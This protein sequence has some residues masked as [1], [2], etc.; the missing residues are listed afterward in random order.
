M[1]DMAGKSILVTGMAGFIGSNVIVNLVKKYPDYYFVGVDKLSYCSTLKNF[2]EI[3]ATDNFVFIEADITDLSHMEQ[4]FEAYNVKIVLHFAAYTHVDHSFAN[5]IIFTNNN[6]LGTH[7]LLEVSKE[8]NVERFIHV[9]TDEVYGDQQDVISVEETTVLV[10]TNPYAATKAAAEHLVRAYHISFGLPII[11]TRGNNVYG[12]KQYPEKVIPKFIFHL[13]NGEKCPI[14]GTGEQKR[15]FLY[16]EDVVSAFDIILHNGV[17]GETYNIG[18][19]TE[20][21]VLE[22]LKELMAIIHPG[23]DFMDYLTFEKD[24]DFNDQRYY[25]SVEKLEK[26]GW[27]KTVPFKEGIRK[28]VK[29]YRD[30]K[31]HFSPLFKTQQ[32][33]DR[34]MYLELLKKCLLNTIYGPCNQHGRPAS[35]TE[36]ERGRYW[37][38]KPHTMIG[39]KRLTNIQECFENVI[40]DGI[41]GDLIETGVWRGGA[42]IFMKGLVDYYKENRKVYVADSF[43]GL[44]PPDPKYPSDSGDEHH[45][46]DYVSVGLDEVKSNFSKYNLLDENVIFVKGYFE[47]SL[48]DLDVEKLA[49]LRLDGD[50][51]FSTIQVLEQLYDKV[52]VGGYVIIDDY[53]LKPCKT[54]VEHFRKSRGITD[55]LKVVD[56]TGRFWRKTKE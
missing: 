21:S 16:T 28:T 36:V 2:E 12:P 25:I 50:M 42:T 14:Q 43:E 54:A 20:H 44:P 22:V 29:W 52:S 4:I 34:P 26:L 32:E 23:K 18:S 40:K 6:V 31:D 17:I 39:E 35:P 38:Q 27:K 3:D 10:P 5:S 45:K 53:V 8:F 13:L 19:K 55:E 11:I 15:S 30:N 41:E 9:S 37:P 48:E 1:E 51:Y 56:Y 33:S 47:E 7:I 49:I 24:R 46:V